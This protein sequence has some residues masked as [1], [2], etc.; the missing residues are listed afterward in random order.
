MRL[1]LFAMLCLVA[2]LHAAGERVVYRLD[3]AQGFDRGVML[4]QPGPDC[5]RID[6]APGGRSGRA[7]VVSVS[8]DASYGGVAN[9][10]PRAEMSFAPSV[11]FALG[12]R[13]VIRWSTFLP[14]DYAP[15][16]QQPE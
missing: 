16:R 4:Q 5:I 14:A 8:R 11:R 7:I 13:Y 3:P 10:A 15:D 1:A 12:H 6:A 9:G 2:P